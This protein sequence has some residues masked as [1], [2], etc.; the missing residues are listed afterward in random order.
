MRPWLLCASLLF[1]LSVA[2]APA[3]AQVRISI[4]VF[5]GTAI[6]I[7][8]G[9]TLEQ[10]GEASIDLTAE[11]E[12]RPFEQPYYWAVRAGLRGSRSSWELQLV[13]HKMYLSNPP[14]GVG[15]FEITHGFNMLTLNYALEYLPVNVRFGG[16]VVVPYVSG[17]VRG[18]DYSSSGY[19]ITGPALLAGVGKGWKVVAGLTAQAEA[20]FS[21]AW[22]R[23]PVSGGSISASNFALHLRAGLGYVF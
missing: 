13:H 7:P 11:Y 18:M 15:N 10:D 17:T 9:L 2:A 3:G 22:A 12:T 8:S 21:A 19:R 16:G 23:V 20:Q 6:S 1:G 4:E 14:E 5:G